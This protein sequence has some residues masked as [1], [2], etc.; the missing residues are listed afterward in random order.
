MIKLGKVF[1]LGDSYSTYKGQMPDGHI[2]WYY[3]GGHENTDVNDFNQTWWKQLLDSTDAIL[4]LNSSWSGTTICNTGYNGADCSDKS[5]IARFDKL[6][7]SGFFV[8]NQIDTFFIFGGTNDTWAGSPVGKE[9]YSDWEKEDLF[10]VLPA[11]SYL[12]SGIKKNLKD[13]RVICLINDGLKPEITQGLKTI[14]EK[15]GVEKIE[16]S[17]IGK[18]GGHPNKEGMT[19]IKDQILKY[20]DEINL[21]Y[22]NL[23]IWL[24]LW[25]NNLNTYNGV[26]Y[27]LDRNYRKYPS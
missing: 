16:L 10:S 11:F 8:Q 5:F 20:L 24:K 22:K 6:S 17:G 23:L 18:Q 4:V 2:S 7:E 19:Q 12:L 14:C 21:Y 15:Y 25:Y 26:V 9:M 13:T 1:I 27:E 3:D